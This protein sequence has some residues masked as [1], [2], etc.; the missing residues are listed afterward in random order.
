MITLKGY[1]D[2]GRVK[3]FGEAP[4]KAGDVL[5]TFTDEWGYDDNRKKLHEEAVKKAQDW[6]SLKKMIHSAHIRNGKLPADFDYKE[7]RLKALD[8]KYENIN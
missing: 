8:E 7:E 1:Y 2:N 4:A 6:E 3:L 5:I